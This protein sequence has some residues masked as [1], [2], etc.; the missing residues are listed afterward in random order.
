MCSGSVVVDSVSSCLCNVWLDIVF[1]AF[2]ACV[3]VGWGSLVDVGHEQRELV[4]PQM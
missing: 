2:S 3:A 4:M 1:G